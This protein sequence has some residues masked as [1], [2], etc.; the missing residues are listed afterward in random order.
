[1]EARSREVGRVLRS[2]IL[3]GLAVLLVMIGALYAA[4]VGYLVLFQRDFVFHPGGAVAS[5]AGLGLRTVETV[6][7]RAKDGTRL[8]GW[9]AAAVPGRPTVL[10]FPGNAGNISGRAERFAE[11][12]GSG[13][14]LLAMSYRGYPGSEGTPSEAGLFSDALEIFD[15]L[16]PR[17]RDIIVHGESLG[18][19]VATYVAAERPARAL[20]LE[21]PYTATV[22]IAAAAYPWVPVSFLMRDQFLSR[23]HIRRVEE[24]VL[25]VH[26]TADEVIPLDHGRRLF[27][28]ANEPKRLEIVEG[29]SHGDLWDRGLWRMVLGFLNEHP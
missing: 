10:Y 14:G 11:I 26:G 22:D 6:E 21:A 15:W 28:V 9:Y 2:R 29:G 20:V 17:S 25:I 12:V 3:K 18:T 19:G 13:F 1:M 7:I 8:T 24:P 16:A 23:E 5:P 4:A 27:E